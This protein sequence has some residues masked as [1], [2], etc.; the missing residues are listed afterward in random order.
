MSGAKWEEERKE[1][2]E[3]LQKAERIALESQAEAALCQD[4]LE[5]YH[6]ATRQALVKNDIKLLPKITQDHFSPIS[7]G[8]IEHWGKLF[9]QAYMRDAK[10]LENTKKALIQI[11]AE[12]EKSSNTYLTERILTF[13]EEGLHEPFESGEKK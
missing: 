3:R 2:L 8:D 13:V 12:A 7:T 6:E 4:L 9:L 10:W 11:K 1:L 5:D